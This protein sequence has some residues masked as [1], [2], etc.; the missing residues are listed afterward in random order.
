MMENNCVNYLF[1]IFFLPV[2]ILINGIALGLVIAFIKS[3]L[4]GVL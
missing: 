2:G 1:W 4:E 3:A